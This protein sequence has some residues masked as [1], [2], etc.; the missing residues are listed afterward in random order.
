MAIPAPPDPTA[1]R[2]DD[3]ASG[4]AGV[5]LH[6][7]DLA[8]AR[9][10]QLRASKLV[11]NAVSGAYRS[12]FL[13]SGIEFEE[14]RPYQPGDD[15]RTID[16]KVTART[17]EPHIKTYRE[18]R[19][20]RVFCVV[21]VAPGMDF[22]S[23]DVGE[24]RRRSDGEERYGRRK[25]DAAPSPSLPATKR[26]MAA[27]LSALIAAAASAEKDAVGLELFGAEPLL[28]LDPEARRDQ[29]L[30]FYREVLGTRPPGSGRG[31]MGRALDHLAGRLRRHALL[32][33][34][35]DFH[36]VLLPD[37]K[38]GE[39]WEVPLGRLAE[40]HDVHCLRIVDP[41]PGRTSSAGD[42]RPSSRAAAGRA[43]TA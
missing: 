12:S 7:A 27:R 42:T 19:Q 25:G 39:G 4:G 32:F 3:R 29:S 26:R 14:V 37:G 34:I 13:G 17:R 20:L 36:D 30:R 1:P 10:L 18:E 21:D 38:L 22:G 16:W 23:R 8:Q 41:R 40:R 11:A 33:V 28:H 9:L 5:E 2:R 31:G 43:P 35:S 6:A 24:R 15:V